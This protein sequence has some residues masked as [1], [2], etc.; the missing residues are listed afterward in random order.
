MACVRS[1]LLYASKTW[2][3][4]I[5]DV[6]RIKRNDN[7]IRWICSSK[8]S[9]KIPML[10]VVNRIE[11]R[12]AIR[13]STCLRISPTPIDGETRTLNGCSSNDVYFEHTQRYRKDNNQRTQRRF[14][15]GIGFPK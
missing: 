15:R 13:P 2:A 10:N 8:L 7:M 6:N 11:W 5:E 9:D 14:Y 3:L 12:N 1:V 4:K